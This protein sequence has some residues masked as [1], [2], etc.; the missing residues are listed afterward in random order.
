MDVTAEPS[1]I[2]NHSKRTPRMP[3]MRLFVSLCRIA[4][5]MSALR[6]V[7][8]PPP[9]LGLV[10]LQ[11]RSL[12][13]KMAAP[14]SS[15]MPSS[16]S[17]PSEIQGQLLCKAWLATN[18]KAQAPRCR[19][20]SYPRDS[21]PQQALQRPWLMTMIMAIMMIMMMMMIFRQLRLPISIIV[22]QTQPCSLLPLSL[23]SL[24]DFRQLRQRLLNLQSQAYR[25]WGLL[26]LGLLHLRLRLVHLRLR[27]V[28][29]RLRLVHLRGP[30]P[31][32]S[33]KMKK[34]PS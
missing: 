31:Q 2:F 30:L 20:S 16:S 6:T 15:S 3:C 8:A 28:H 27:L 23:R 33:L 7:A 5:I 12:Y 11:P 13:N 4:L 29:L 22:P 24:L 17:F 18:C 1:Y 14:P 34:G 26:R 10:D 21:R 32:V 19:P 25:R 9:V